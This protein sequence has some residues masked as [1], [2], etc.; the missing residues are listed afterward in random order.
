VTFNRAALI[1]QTPVYC[2][3]FR[4]GGHLRTNNGISDD[5]AM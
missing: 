2:R 1:I 5:V 3:R 4:S